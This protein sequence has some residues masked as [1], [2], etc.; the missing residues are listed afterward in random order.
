MRLRSPGIDFKVMDARYN[1]DQK[2]YTLKCKDL[3]VEIKEGENILEQIFNLE[4]YKE[5]LA[6]AKIENVK[7]VIRYYST[8]FEKQI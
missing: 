4:E 8:W 5:V 7:N 1:F 3:V 2:E 6:L